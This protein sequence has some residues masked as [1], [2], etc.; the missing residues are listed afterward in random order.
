MELVPEEKLAIITTEQ[1][2]LSPRNKNMEETLL[3][4]DFHVNLSLEIAVV[5]TK[6]HQSVVPREKYPRVLENITKLDFQN[7]KISYLQE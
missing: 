5:L 7:W 4:W 1:P 3:P 2:I 6:K